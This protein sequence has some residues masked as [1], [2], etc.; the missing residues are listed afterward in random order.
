MLTSSASGWRLPL[1]DACRFTGTTF[2]SAPEDYEPWGIVVRGD[3]LPYVPAH[4]CSSETQPKSVWATRL[5]VARAHCGGQGVIPDE[6]T[7][8]GAPG[9]SRSQS[10]ATPVMRWI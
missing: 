8:D 5:N 10:R 1:H 7:T 3:E 2:R 9:P 6:Q 4:S